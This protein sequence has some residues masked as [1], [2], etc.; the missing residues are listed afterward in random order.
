MSNPLFQDLFAISHDVEVRVNV[1]NICN[2]HCD[3]CDHG[4]HIPFSR[5]SPSI[6]RRSPYVIQPEEIDTF[7]R[8]LTGVGEQNTHLLQGGEITV[9]PVDIIAQY[10]EVF[11]AF[12]RQV[13]LRTNGYNV[14][15]LPIDALNRLGRIYLNSHGTNQ[16]AI[17]RSREFLAQHY[18]GKLMVEQTLYHR[19]LD[20]L[21]NHGIGIVEQ[22]RRCN[23]LMTTLTVIPPVLYPCCNS[24]A[25]M[26]ALNSSQMRDAFIDA[27]WTL[28][29]PRLRETLSNWRH[30]LPKLF[31]EAFCANSCYVNL[32]P[33]RIPLY[34]IQPHP[35]DRVMKG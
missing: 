12:G 32:P 13:G 19:D 22:G 14:A 3:Y 17:R 5:N 30:T 26:N 7:C 28:D 34:R 23:C 15:G 16:D 31:Y 27:G 20:S 35:R 21:V 1:T 11:H 18:V 29:N 24:W 10:I 4:C 9:L 8:V 33:E 2:L 25:L 6:F